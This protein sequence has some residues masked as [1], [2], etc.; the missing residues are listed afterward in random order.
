MAYLKAA[1]DSRKRGSGKP[2]CDDGAE[3]VEGSGLGL[4]EVYRASSKA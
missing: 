1:E 2:I 4:G 3:R